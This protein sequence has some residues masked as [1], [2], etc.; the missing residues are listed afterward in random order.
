MTL[1]LIIVAI[2]VLICA[3]RFFKGVSEKKEKTVEPEAPVVKAEDKPRDPKTGR[4][5]KRS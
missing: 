5:I 1:V 3:V 4:F 2:V